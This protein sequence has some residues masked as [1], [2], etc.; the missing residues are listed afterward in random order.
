MNGK[1]EV[2]ERVLQDALDLC[3]PFLSLVT[4]D[5][6]MLLQWKATVSV[7]RSIRRDICIWKAALLYPIAMFM[8]FPMP[9]S[10]TLCYEEAYEI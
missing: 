7:Y 8:Y 6:C 3:L 4:K 10:S 5:E 1:L 9:K 2:R